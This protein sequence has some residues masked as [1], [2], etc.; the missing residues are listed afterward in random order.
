M[1]LKPKTSGVSETTVFVGSL[2]IH[3]VP[4]TIYH[5]ICATYYIL[6]SIYHMPAGRKEH[7]GQQGDAPAPVRGRQLRH[8]DYIPYTIL[9]FIP[10]AIYHIWILAFLCGVL[11]PI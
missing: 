8:L 11:G 6:Y 10:N 2:F 5:I 1:V 3:H 4:Y 9:Y 7:A